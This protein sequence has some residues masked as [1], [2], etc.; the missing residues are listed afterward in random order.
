MNDRRMQ[1]L[2]NWYHA[3]SITMRA[4]RRKEE[5]ALGRTRPHFSRRQAGICWMARRDDKRNTSH[6]TA[7]SERR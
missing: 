1:G 4:T 5:T 3:A 7:Q 2:R 6:R